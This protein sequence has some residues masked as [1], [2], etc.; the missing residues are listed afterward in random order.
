MGASCQ[1]F[2]AGGENSCSG[3]CQHLLTRWGGFSSLGDFSIFGS[4]KAEY[5][6]ELIR[7]TY[8]RNSG[9]DWH[10]VALLERT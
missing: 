3:F 9:D 1:A 5:G 10:N 8:H 4:R 6:K 2:K 7:F